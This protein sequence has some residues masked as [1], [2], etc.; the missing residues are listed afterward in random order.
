MDEAAAI[1]YLPPPIS[2]P[3]LADSLAIRALEI[4]QVIKSAAPVIPVERDAR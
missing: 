2:G 3:Y 4:I 1:Y